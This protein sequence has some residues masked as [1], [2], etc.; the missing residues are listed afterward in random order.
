MMVSIPVKVSVVEPGFLYE[1]DKYKLAATISSNAG[2]TVSGTLSLDVYGGSGYK[3]AK[4]LVSFRRRVT[5]G[6]GDA[7]AETFPVDV[8][9]GVDTLGFKIVFSAGEFSDAVFVPVKVLKAEQE[10]T[11]AH[12]AVLL[13]GADREALIADL[14]GRFVNADPDKASFREVTILD[15][16]KE[17]IPDKIEPERPDVLSLSEAWYCSMLSAKLRGEEPGAEAGELLKKVLACRNSD[18]GFGW[19]EGMNSSAVITAVVLERFE[20]LR[21]R[22]VEVPDLTSSVEFLD[23]NQFG[24]EKPLWCGWLSDAQY[25]HVR[26]MYAEVPFEVKPV[27]QADKK[28]MTEFRKYA[29]EYLTPSGKRGLEG[30]ILAKARRLTTL[31]NLSASSAGISLAKAWGI[32]WSSKLEKSIKA[33]VASLL[34][35]A[36]RHRDGG[37]YYPNAVMPWRGLLESEAYAHAMLSGLLSEDSPEIADGVRLWL[38]LQKE[39][40]K[41]ETDPAFVDAIDAILS[42]SDDV[43]DTRV[44]ALSGTYD[45]PFKDIK[46]SGNGFTLERRFFRDGE[47]LHPGDQVYVGDKIA[48][49]YIIWNAENRSFVK[50][51]SPREAALQ[52]TQQLSGRGGLGVLTG[53]TRLNGLYG[54]YSWNIYRNV[55]AEC[56]EYWWEVCPEENNTLTEEFYV[57]RAGAFSAPVVTIESLYAPHYRANAASTGV[58]QAVR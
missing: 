55:K 35:Y 49:Q 11:E 12:S 57:V 21:R 42:G 16:I 17:A 52:P 40:Q 34:E 22:G 1:G 27:L 31:R 54:F 43:L 37:F 30:R 33:D 7:V 20:L 5:V 50:L 13:Y 18:G 51:V 26:A 9:S 2:E 41:W 53:N 24:T 58:L 4:P 45:G 36:V 14:K 25:M 28:R 29:K 32:S 47:E 39:T 3:G 38:M 46:A 44:L 19:F 48:A 23:R 10:L 56:T 15:M 8:P 6:D